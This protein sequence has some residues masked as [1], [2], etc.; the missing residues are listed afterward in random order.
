MLNFIFFIFLLFFMEYERGVDL[1]WHSGKKNSLLVTILT[2][3]Q[4]KIR[5]NMFYQ[6][7]EVLW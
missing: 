7:K 5:V 2:I 3:K 6:V 1:L 4:V